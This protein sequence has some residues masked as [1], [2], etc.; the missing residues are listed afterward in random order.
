MQFK[1]RLWLPLT[2]IM[3]LFVAAYWHLSRNVALDPRIV[4]YDP[5]TVEIVAGSYSV[6]FDEGAVSKAQVETRAAALIDGTGAAV[7]HVFRENLRGFTVT[8]LSNAAAN[9][10]V[11]EPD[12]RLV[13]QEFAIFG[14]ELR[15]SAWAPVLWHLDRIDQR[16]PLNLDRDFRFKTGPV[17]TAQRV[18]VYVLDN[19]INRS[20]QEFQENGISRV[21]DVEDVT[22]SNPASKFARCGLNQLDASHGTAIA[23]LVAGKTYG[24]VTTAIKNVRVLRA[25]GV[26]AT[27]IWGTPDM[28]KAGLETVS[29]DMS[30]TSKAIVVLSLGWEQNTPDFDSFMQSFISIQNVIVIAAAGNEN[31]NAD[32]LTPAKLPGV[33]AVGAVNQAGSRYLYSPTTGSN[34]GAKVEIWAPGE[35]VTSAGWAI[36]DQNYRDAFSGTSFAAPLVAGAMSLHWQQYPTLTAA[37][38]KVAVIER[39]TRHNLLNLGTNANNKLLYVGEAAPSI[40]GKYEPNNTGRYISVGVAAG[41]PGEPIV[42]TGNGSPQIQHFNPAAITSGPAMPF[43]A[44]LSGEVRCVKQTELASI[45]PQGG[46]PVDAIFIGCNVRNASGVETGKVVAWRNTGEIVWQADLPEGTELNGMTQAQISTSPD[47]ETFVYVLG[48]HRLVSGSLKAEVIKL[49]GKNGQILQSSDLSLVGYTETF[50][51]GVDIRIFQ[52]EHEPN[53]YPSTFALVALTYSD[54]PGPDSSY[55][56]RLDVGSAS[57][58]SVEKIPASTLAENGQWAAALAVQP[59]EYGGPNRTIPPVVYVATIAM[60][61]NGPNLEPWSYVYRLGSDYLTAGQAIEVLK[62]V[63]VS[64]MWCAD[65]DLFFAGTTQR[66]YAGNDTAG[67]PRSATTAQTDAY[68]AKSE[69][70]YNSLRWV[71]TF[72]RGDNLSN[73]AESGTYGNG[74]AYIIGRAVNHTTYIVQY[75]VY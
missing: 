27:C 10:I 67:T 21:Q 42:V 4:T 20:H 59:L 23:A 14:K 41:I 74:N 70:A 62:G 8:N 47:L 43:T 6:Q 48:T 58:L 57:P 16:V 44:T 28:V 37:Q 54:P 50:T 56:W 22:T 60:V 39:S 2:L 15:G 17:E 68:L 34:F 32:S 64:G 26:P 61:R 11:Q 49:D 51:R 38:V 33:V 36:A 63:L 31:K 55:V 52:K 73:G 69:G 9:R 24:V 29:L 65:N 75:P 25:G 1:A 72:D 53:R 71:R 19:G 66:T 5:A 45:D 13:R 46:N 30:R 3:L 35:N 40:H 12:V 7:T 18:P